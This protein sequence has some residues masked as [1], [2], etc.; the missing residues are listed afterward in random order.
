MEHASLRARAAA[1]TATLGVALAGTLV[2]VSAPAEAALTETDYGFKTF[3]LGSTVKTG[4][5]GLTSAPTAYSYLG[6]TRLAGRTSDENVAAVS[7]PPGSAALTIGAVTSHSE[8]FRSGGDVGTL[9]TNRISSV[10]IGRADGVHLEL[11]GLET[12]AKVWADKYGR[13]HEQATFKL[14]DLVADTGTPLDQLNGVTG[15]LFTQLSDLLK[16]SDGKMEIPGFGRIDLGRKWLRDFGSSAKAQAIALRMVVYTQQGEDIDLVLG[17]SNARIYRNLPAGVMAGRGYA[18]SVEDLQGLVSVG[19]VA[20]QPLPCAGT[21]GKIKT[22]SASGLLLGDAGALGLGAASSQVYGIQNEDGSAKAWTAGQINGVTLGSGN[23]S[24]VIK[25]GIRGQANVIRKRS[26]KLARNAE[27]SK[28]GTLS[29]GGQEQ[30][31]P[32]PGDVIEIPGLGTMKFF[33][34]EYPSPR[35]IRVTA[36]RIFLDPEAQTDIGLSRIDLGV[37]YTFL[38]RY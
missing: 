6:C 29:I 19:R 2:I 5:A 23:T 13:F 20:K 34:K 18:A 21:R 28:I 33:V 26:G 32:S 31:I 11:K 7:A 22:K 30:D 27:G 4:P 16:S 24:L 10:N 9:S 15:P 38:K 3:S 8:T 37:G 14:G 1:A 25:G 12:T 17:R 35:A 36:V